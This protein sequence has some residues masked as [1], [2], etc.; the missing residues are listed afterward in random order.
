MIEAG[1]KM[2]RLHLQFAGLKLST[3]VVQTFSTVEDFSMG[4]DGFPMPAPLQ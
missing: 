3:L 1:I 4:L 2:S